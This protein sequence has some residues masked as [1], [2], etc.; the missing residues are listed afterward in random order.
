MSKQAV[1]A[2]AIA[3]ALATGAH[4]A[5]T[6]VFADN[7]NHDALGLNST[8]DGWTIS[9]GTVDT[10]GRSNFFDLLPGN[11]RYVDLD[12]STSQAGT[13]TKTFTGLADGSYTLSFDLAG[14][15][16]A[17]GKEDV[18]VNFG[19]TSAEYTPGEFKDFTQHQLTGVAVNG[20]LTLSFQDV[21][22]DNFGA[23]LDRVKI[24]TQVSQVP[25]PASGAL[26]LAGLGA[27]GFAARRRKI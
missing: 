15:Q 6:T 27:I 23:L 24:T 12:G 26:L 1:L 22:S 11:G 21:S 14:N 9:G 10:I 18:H 3:G 2:F 19:G 13:M 8:P 16:R 20:V 4:A 25:E 17:A 7:F 5:T